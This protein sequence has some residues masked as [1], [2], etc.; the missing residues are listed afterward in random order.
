MLNT[1]NMRYMQGFLWILL[2]IVS[3]YILLLVLMYLFQISLMYHPVKALP[4]TPSA[5]G[6]T[7]EEAWFSTDDSV[8]IHGW[9]IPAEQARG[10][11]LFSHGNAGNI[12]G[13]LETIRMLH[14]LDM[15]V[16]IYDYR[17][18]GKSEGSA[19]EEGT[20][21]D[22]L[23]AWKFL[24]E[25]KEIPS[26]SIIIMG[27]SLGGGVSAWLT[28]KTNPRGLILESTFT[29]AK[30]L[31]QE[32]YPFFPVGWLMKM[33]YPTQKHI[34]KLSIPKLILHSSDDQLI[35][36]HHGREL[37]ESTIEP[38]YFF[39][40]QGDHGGGHVVTGSEYVEAL[41]HFIINTL[42]INKKESE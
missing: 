28:T 27:R 38:K 17:G 12:S 3:G 8:S 30:D 1:Q 10:T 35:P 11:I 33:E 21:K 20:Y 2:A 24:T 13:R 15:N 41:D 23:A 14:Q 4:Y 32:L 19:S 22:V 36:Y 29:S 31:A 16:L 25:E 9:Y 7:Y 34:Q 26:D 5:I 42:N 18:Y 37:Y 39:E 40:M 6:L